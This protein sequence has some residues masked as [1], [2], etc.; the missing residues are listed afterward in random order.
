LKYLGLKNPDSLLVVP[1]RFNLDRLCRQ[2]LDEPIFLEEAQPVWV[3]KFRIVSRRHVIMEER[4]SINIT[5]PV[6]K[7]MAKELGRQ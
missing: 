3:M 7:L 4:K 5:F 1:T 2:G 6:F